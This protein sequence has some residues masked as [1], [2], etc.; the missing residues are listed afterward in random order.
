MTKALIACLWIL[1]GGSLSTQALH[2]QTASAIQDSLDFRVWNEFVAILRK[3]PLPG[4]RIAPY[5]EDLRQPLRGFLDT[6]RATADW[7]EWER[8]PDRYRVGQQLHF[9][10]RLTF[11]GQAATYCFSFVTS[12]SGWKFQHLEAIT[13]RLDQLGPFPV[14]RFPDLP[15]AEKAWMREELDVTRDVHWLRA[16]AKEKGW[17]TALGWFADG[18]G[19]ALAARAWVP[20]VTPE[21]AFILYLCWEQA[22]LHGAE[23]TLVTLEQTAAVV[24]LRPIYFLLYSRSAHLRNQIS[25]ADFRRLFEYRWQDRAKNAGWSLSIAYEGDDCILRFSRLRRHEDSRG[26]DR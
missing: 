18:A 16:L 9:V 22:R 24:R 3:G 14:R 19:Y 20:Y 2:A 11:Q 7:G 5:L 25:L 17:D 1:V 4:E 10:T 8:A 6:M 23:V 21:R 26:G 12:A 13:L 15:E